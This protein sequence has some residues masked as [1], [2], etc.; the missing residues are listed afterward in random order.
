M[1]ISPYQ[2]HHY[3]CASLACGILAELEV[4]PLETDNALEKERLRWVMELTGDTMYDDHTYL[5]II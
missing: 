3:V 1:R 5:P 4:L 2:V